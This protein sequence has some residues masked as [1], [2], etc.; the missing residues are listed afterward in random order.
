MSLHTFLLVLTAASAVLAAWIVARFPRMT[1]VGARQI[2]ISIVGAA[3]LPIVADR[4]IPLVG[5]PFGG[6]AALFLVVLPGSIYLFLVA[7]WIMLFVKQAIA[8]FLR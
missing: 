7:A 1:R 6:V 5:V 3:F 8:P 4:L 2:T